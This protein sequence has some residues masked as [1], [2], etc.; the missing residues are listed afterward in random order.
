MSKS[1]F[2]TQGQ[3][4]SYLQ[5]NRSDS[6]GSVWGT[7]NV[8]L[9]TDLNTMRS[10]PR[11]LIGANTTSNANLGLPVAFSYIDS[12]MWAIAGTR[13]FRNASY[14]TDAW[15]EDTSTGHATNF[16]SA[17]DIAIFNELLW[18]TSADTLYSKALNGSGTGAWTSRATTFVANANILCYFPTFNRLYYQY[19]TGLVKSID[20]TFTIST[21]AYQ[22]DLGSG[23]AVS[24][25]VSNSTYVWVGVSGVTSVQGSVAQIYA[26]DGISAAASKIYTLPSRYVA[27]MCVYQDIVYCMDGSGILYKFNGYAFD[28]I[29]RLP[30]PTLQPSFNPF[31]IQRNGMMATKN[32]TILVMISNKNA[33]NTASYQEN[34]PSGV[35]EWSKDFG[36]THKY[37]P[38]YTLASNL[39]SFTDYGQN[40][41]FAPGAIFDVSEIS[42]GV[43]G[44]NG[45][46]L[47]GATY[48]TNGSSTTNAIFV[49]DRND[50]AIK[51][52]YFVTTWFFSSEVQDKWTRLWVVFRKIL[53]QNN[54]MVFKYRTTE[55]D[56][57]Y[58]AITWTGTNT[59]TTTT[60]PSA[61]WTSGQGTGGEV[62][63]LQGPGSGI[64]A[65]ITQIT[66]N[67]GTY[68]VHLDNVLTSTSLSGSTALCRFQKWVK[69][70]PTVS[71]DDGNLTKGWAQM[72][73]GA[74]D[75]RIQLK[76][77][78]T[79]TGPGEFYKL[80]MF[81]NED[82]KINA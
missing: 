38:T 62:E 41:I 18:A 43:S 14:P 16:S 63:I 10:A 29:G 39:N 45:S 46:I 42:T 69:L 54:S 34:L 64:C 57:L 4:Y 51:K 50:T 8:D 40:I 71:F 65:H 32:G 53:T 68:T 5:T 35:W 82:I 3:K 30:F 44:D 73:M 80:A 74:S 37:S 9:Q 79:L 25:M 28:E 17:S 11:L 48:Y 1:Y 55:E 59:F 77:C 61:Y 76:G 21:D 60:N 15:T 66:N 81:S 26:W 56:P 67:S 33:G 70:F 20:T 6:L 49:D 72:G 24:C 36:F 75:P 52:S 27:A 78:L 19:T 2:P 47:V 7:M 12:C 23:T 22:L 31:Y 13:V 58:A